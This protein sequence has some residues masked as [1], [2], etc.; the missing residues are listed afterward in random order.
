MEHRAILPAFGV[1]AAALVLAA[2]GSQAPA[3]DPSGT[4]AKDDGSAKLEVVADVADEMRV[5]IVAKV[6]RSAPTTV[7]NAAS[8][9]GLGTTTEILEPLPSLAI[10]VPNLMV[11]AN[12]SSV[13]AAGQAATPTRVRQLL[14]PRHRSRSQNR[15]CMRRK[16][17]R[18][19]YG[20]PGY[21]HP[22]CGYRGRR[23]AL[24]LTP[25][26]ACKAV[27]SLAPPLARI[28]RVSRL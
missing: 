14:T 25:N 18:P 1:L 2:I 27:A 17:S 28:P 23:L 9:S 3:A 15:R 22:G 8:D 6:P 20:R 11:M 19:G 16:C 13:V 21:G 4:S 5:S 7:S 24:R 26:W 10:T 12:F